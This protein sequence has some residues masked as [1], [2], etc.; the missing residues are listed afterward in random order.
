MAT[1]HQ[2]A[3]R[4]NEAGT[5]NRRQWARYET[6]PAEVA[7]TLGRRQRKGVVV[8]ESIGGVG[9]MMVD[10]KKLDEGVEVKLQYRG[11]EVPAA[12]K[13]V[14]KADDGLYHVGF[15]WL[16]SAIV[17][18]PAVPKNR[19]SHAN[20][21]NHQ[22]V[23]L[24]CDVL[25]VAQDGTATIALWDGAYFEVPSGRVRDDF[26]PC[27][28]LGTSY[29]RRRRILRRGQSTSQDRSSS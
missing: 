8:D 7:V 9:V 19:K 22:G 25:E 16:D 1:D 27:V 13:S 24:A 5:D 18:A 15:G 3:K 23:W 17:N 10:V 14:R 2:F 20:F 21:V 11:I 6:D 29:R 12:V 4:E 28:W 26:R